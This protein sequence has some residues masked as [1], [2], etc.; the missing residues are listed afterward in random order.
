[1]FVANDLPKR[2]EFRR[3]G[4]KSI[5]SFKQI[6][7]IVFDFEMFKKFDEFFFE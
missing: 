5:Y 2:F 7:F 4:I 1:M 6:F 3:N